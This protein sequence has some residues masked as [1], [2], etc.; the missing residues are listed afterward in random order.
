MRASLGNLNTNCGLFVFPNEILLHTLENL[1]VSSFENVARVPM[2]KQQADAIIADEQQLDIQDYLPA[3][4]QGS[5]D[6]MDVEDNG[7]K[8]DSDG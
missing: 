1:V 5:D 4:N 6:E 3:N 8:E 7:D 2:S